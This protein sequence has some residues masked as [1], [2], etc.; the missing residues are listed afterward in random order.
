MGSRKPKFVI[1]LAG[2]KG[3][4]MRSAD[5]H[6]VCF[7]I[8]G[9]PAI[10]RAIDIYKAC[11]IEQPVVVV[12][13]MAGQVMET[14]G[15]AHKDVI[16]TYQAEQLGTG[17][18]ARVGLA[19]LE[20]LDADQDVLLV[21]GDRIVEPFILD[22][23][24]DLYYA[25]GCDMAFLVG[26][27]GRRSDKGRILLNPDGS[28]LA[29]VEVRDIW[30][31]EA[32]G[33]IRKMALDG[34]PP[35]RETILEIIG[36]HFDPRRAAKAFGRLWQAVY[37]AERQP[38][39]AELLAWIPEERTHFAFTRVDG[40]E[41]TL[42]PAEVEATDI[43]NLSIYLLKSSALRYALAN[44]STDNAQGE[45][46]LSDMITILAQTREDGQ[47]R[48][49]VEALKVENPNHVMAFNDPAE[50][51]EIEAYFQRK[52][53]PQPVQEPPRGRGYRPITDWQKAFKDL[54]IRGPTCKDSTNPLCQEL[55]ELY[56]RDADLLAKRKSGYLELLTA[57]ADELGEDAPVMLIHA[58]GRVNILGR[59]I[60]HQGGNCNLMA[61][62]R[63]ILMA[64]HPRSDDEIHLY[65]VDQDEFAYRE[66]SI[67]D[68][69]KDLPWED[70]MSLINSEKLAEMVC[71]AAGD[72]A[73][74]VQAAVLRLQKK[75]PTIKLRGMDLVVLGDIP[76][77][78]GLSSSS[79]LV[80]ASAEAT[81][82]VNQL[83]VFPSQFVDLCGEGEWFVGT[84]GGSADHAAVKFGQK[85]RVAKVRF[86]EFAVE[87]MVDFPAKHRVVICNS[88]V[89]A[90]K[91]ANAR[92]IFNQ[93]VTCYHVGRELVKKLFPQYAPLI[94]HLRDINA[95]TLNVPLARIYRI[96]LRLPERATRDEIRAALPDFQ[97]EPLFASHVP[98]EEGY[99]IR[100]VVLFG[101]GECER[102]RIAADL[103]AEGAVE[104]FGR[105]M[106]T[107]HDGD[108]VVTYDQDW[109]PQPHD[110]QVSNS[111]LL[112]L[113][114]DLES[115]DPERVI[116]A[117]LQW[118]P[119]AYACSTP[120][121]DLM[122]EVAKRT[123]GVMGAQIAGAG[124]GGCMMVLAHEAATA[125]LRERM[126]DLY[127]G[128][129]DLEPDISVCIPIGGSGV[130]FDPR[131]A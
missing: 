125:D 47:P 36:E 100:D 117:Q 111:Y 22:G 91:S 97:V 24:I 61:I 19:A 106:N 131:G 119:G 51:L 42:T 41:I 121:I 21:A 98:P 129:R 17:H 94:R 48:Y 49:H 80:V 107:S 73:Q 45:E 127:Y 12:G 8:D 13:Y 62:D 99:P 69:L 102:S 29:D 110:Y 109:N 130:L 40:T 72:W 37:E 118:Q 55:I 66:F 31:R 103:L 74:Y 54:E 76:I 126:I 101:L 32:Y 82:S 81:V 70:W 53:Q 113:L 16:Y 59:H 46:Y 2:G 60:D 27:K 33:R 67:S 64:V 90:K 120:E 26:P 65:N 1:I 95:R 96:L 20:S 123:P 85:G 89:Q 52:K 35:S 25:R 28:V 124:L 58:P 39:A 112:D 57:A 92:D 14:V 115:G 7:P 104:E 71:A 15:E 93:R 30:Q 23:L 43:A 122:V 108:R 50:L 11:G 10:N 6:K 3:T 86:F 79:A 63:E 18:A 114:E 34:E 4:R 116:P 5:R 88:L 68:L 83:A 128:P 77:A 9:R 87:D 44:L 84:R 38:T 75:F 78:A 105:L 56:G